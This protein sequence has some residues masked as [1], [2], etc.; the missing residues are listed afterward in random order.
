MKSEVNTAY[1]YLRVSS[2]GQGG[3]GKDGF[4]RQ[5]EACMKYAAAHGLKIVKVFREPV[6]GTAEWEDRPAFVNMMALLLA[7]G[8]HT[9]LVENLSRLARLLMIQEG[10]IEDFKRKGLTLISVN[11]P[12]LCSDDPARIMLRQVMGA[13]YQ[14]QK[15]M[16]VLQTRAA[17]QRKRGQG[18]RVT[19]VRCEGRKPYGQREGEQTVL[20]RMK[21]LREA[22]TGFDAI[23]ATLN[24]EGLL[25]RYGKRWFGSSICK[26]LKTQTA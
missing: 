20:E 23:A 9:V 4:P 2:K 1:I 24:A 3:E 22:R 10:I 12:D 11:E 13:F 26:I 8:T 25:T 5:E 21:M 14:Y 16:F 15:T 17:R 19:G 18:V 6:T 7:N